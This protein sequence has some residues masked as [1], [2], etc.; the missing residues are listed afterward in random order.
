M[1]KV[2]S[3]PAA[4][5]VTVRAVCLGLFFGALIDLSVAYNDDVLYNTLLVGTHLPLI[6]TAIVLALILGFNGFAARWLRV[7]GLATGELLLIWAIMGVMGGIAGSGLMRYLGPWMAVPAYYSNSANEWDVNVL[8]FLPDWMV[9]SRDQGNTAVK[10]YMEGLPRGESIPWGAWA[11]PMAAW[12]GFMLLLYAACFCLVSLFYRH[13]AVSERLVFPLVQLPVLMA[14]AP[15]PGRRF[16]AFFRDPLTWVGIAIP[17][18]IWGINGL[19]SYYPGVPVIPMTLS[20]PSLF[21]DRPWNVFTLG[22]LNVWFTV[23][24][25]TYL[26]TVENGFSLWFFYILY[27]L[28]FVFVAWL[29]SGATG[30]WG[31][32]GI[33]VTVFETAGAVLAIAGFLFWTARRFI[34]GWGRRALA[35]RSDPELDPIPPRP[36]LALMLLGIAGMAGW[37]VLAGA[38]WWAALLA[39]LLFLALLLVLTR[40]VAEAGL[41]YVQCPMIPHDVLVGLFP[42]HLFS[43]F[44]LNAM[45]MQKAIVMQDLREAMMPY[46]MNGINAANR[47]RLRLGHVLA[48]FALAA[49]VALA[50][51]AYGRITTGYKYGA[52][53]MDQWGAVW[54]PPDFIG[55]MVNYRKYPPNYERTAIGEVKLLPVN[56]AHVLT[57]GML[58]IGM[59]ALRARFLWWPLHPF[60]LVLCG[61]WAMYVIWFSIFLGWAAKASVMT[62]GGAKVYRRLLPFFLGMVL[63]EALILVCWTAVGFL[64]GTPAGAALPRG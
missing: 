29:G 25:L 55:S 58:A 1:E 18:V 57:G 46:I 51:S 43:G 45:N 62:F 12:G 4:S 13:W 37:L 21:P 35:G 6:A 16:N 32:W 54:C 49:V 22:T 30:Y 17:T 23:V 61:S 59:L 19:S 44:T 24:G 31:E 42:S 56:V 50:I 20:V 47:A 10:W 64:T 52:V 33:K 9:L 27:Q 40:I 39:V 5:P 14:G 63:G 48:V 34:A 41:V 8:K 53:N 60:G 11:V 15:E 26:L 36:A 38:Q 2:I 28:S 7:P 3:A